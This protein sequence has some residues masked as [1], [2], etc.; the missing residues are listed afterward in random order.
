[1]LYFFFICLHCVFSYSRYF[2]ILCIFLSIFN[3]LFFNFYI[4][5]FL[6]NSILI[7]YI[8]DIKSS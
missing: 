6:T 1:M 3:I 2:L 8:H 4:L 5:I 7:Q